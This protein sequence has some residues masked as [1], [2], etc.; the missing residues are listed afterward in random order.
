MEGHLTIGPTTLIY[1]VWLSA[2]ALAL[3]KVLSSGLCQDR[4]ISLRRFDCKPTGN[5]FAWP[6]RGPICWWVGWSV[7]S[8]LEEPPGQRK[9]GAV[10]SSEERMKLIPA[11]GKQNREYCC[12]RSFCM[13]VNANPTCSLHIPGMS[14][15]IQSEDSKSH[16]RQASAF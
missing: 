9:A 12:Q 6:V 5:F 15:V 1:H 13:S 14:V 10:K 16:C 4:H 11:Q 8:S 7:N 2:H 3:A